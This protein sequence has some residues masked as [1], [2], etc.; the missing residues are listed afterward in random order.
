MFRP[1]GVTTK[2]HSPDSKEIE[3]LLPESTAPQECYRLCPAVPRQGTA[4]APHSHSRA[5]GRCRETPA[6]RCAMPLPAGLIPPLTHRAQQSFP[7][8]TK[9][10][11]QWAHCSCCPCVRGLGSMSHRKRGA[12]GCRGPTPGLGAME[13]LVPGCLSAVPPASGRCSLRFSG[14]HSLWMLLTSV[15]GTGTAPAKVWGSRVCGQENEEGGQESA[16]HGLDRP[17]QVHRHRPGPRPGRELR[18]GCAE[19][20]TCARGGAAGW[21]GRLCAEGR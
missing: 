20:L 21:R 8:L 15:P 17:G 4:P 18:L 5:S 10:S 16:R 11:L 12:L 1:Q 2:F 6:G 9:P 19:G 13:G 7:S 14:Y 3:S